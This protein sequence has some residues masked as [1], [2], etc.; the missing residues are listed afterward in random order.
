MQALVGSDCTYVA[1]TCGIP[2]QDAKRLDGLV[3][4]AVLP[5]FGDGPLP[6]SPARTFLPEKDGGL[7]FQSVEVMAP[8]AQAASWHFC[9]PHVLERFHLGSVAALTARSPIAND[10]MPLASNIIRTSLDDNTVSVGDRD[11]AVSQYSI[12]S[13]TYSAAAKAVIDTAASD[14]PLCASIRSASGRGAAAWLRAPSK[15]CHRMLNAQ[16][17][18]ALRTRLFLDMPT[19]T[20][21]CR[22]RRPN[23]DYCGVAL[24]AKGTHA[25][26]CQVGGW[27]VKRHN[28]G[29]EILAD[30]AIRRCGCTVF[31]EQVL[32]TA[33]DEHSEARMD[34]IVHSPLVSGAL[35]IDLTVVSALSVD[36][37]GNGA[38][39]RDGVASALASRRKV[40]KY[41][42]TEVYPF[43]VEDHGRIGEA[44][45]T[46]IRMLA[47]V[48][49]PERGIAIAELQRDLANTLQRASADS[50]LAAE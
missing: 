42:N 41:P 3:Y 5:P 49:N 13:A 14:L 28:A 10:F 22:H 47:P 29:V 11:L 30:W 2:K 38:A 21:R 48:D 46:V 32:P 27:L 40:R 34:L 31:K 12:A 1:R 26:R 4:D 7:G 33:R 19:M 43:A 39:L 18:L 20:G 35:Q 6:T 44:A 24:D 50:I 36:A 23:G 25:R 37:L 17:S 15:P 9:T 16:F 45:V 8:A